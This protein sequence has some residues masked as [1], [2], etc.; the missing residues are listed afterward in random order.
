MLYDILDVIFRTIFVQ[1][2]CSFA[3]VLSFNVIKLCFTF[4]IYAAL[5]E[6]MNE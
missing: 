2:L 5:S 4:I 1:R 3:V 6:C